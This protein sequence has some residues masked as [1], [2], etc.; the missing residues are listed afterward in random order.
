MAAVEPKRWSMF[1]G[2]VVPIPTL[3]ADVILIASEYAVAAERF[4]NARAPAALPSLMPRM[5]DT[6]ARVV[7]VWKFIPTAVPVVLL[8]LFRIRP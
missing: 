7:P 6:P 3:P 4:P 2:V 8:W 5:Y 1:A